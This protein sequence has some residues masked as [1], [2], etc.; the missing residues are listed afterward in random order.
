[1]LTSWSEQSTPP[2]L[3]TKSVLM[4]PPRSEYSMR[5]SCEKPRL[6]PSPTTLQRRSRPSTRTASLVRS[7]TAEFAS[8]E[9]LTYV[10]MPPFHSRST[11]S[12]RIAR[13][14][15]AGVALAGFDAEQCARL[16]RQRDLLGVAREHAA[17]L[18]DQ[19]RVVVGPRGAGQVEQPLALL[20]AAR[21]VGLGIEEDVLVVERGDEP[22]VLRQ[23]HAVA[24]DVAGHVA[25]AGDR[26]VL[27]SACRRP[28]RGND[29]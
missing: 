17:A 24:E 13:M 12:F 11:G 15:S 29:A 7:P 8:H 27:R 21:R 18:R 20:V 5:P 3:S 16:R 9:A 19:L 2:E 14:I 25:D 4:R 10:P 6:P 26:E 22:D 28:F 1:M 23:Q